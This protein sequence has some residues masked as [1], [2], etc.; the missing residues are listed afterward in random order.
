MFLKLKPSKIFLLALVPTL[1]I[2][3]PSFSQ[4]K[5]IDNEQTKLITEDG[6]KIGFQK[7][8]IASKNSYSIL[9][10]NN[11]LNT[12]VHK[13]KELLKETISIN[14]SQ[15]NSTI[16]IPFNIG[17]D[18]RII[19]EKDENGKAD[20]AAAI[21]NEK[22]DTIG[23]ISTPTIEDENKLEISSVSLKDKN[24]LQLKLE[25][26]DV[27]NT[28]VN[29]LSVALAATYYSTYFSSG[30]WITR[31]GLVSLSL[32]HKPYLFSGT[33]NERSL[34]RSD[35]WNKVKAVH[36]GNSKWKNTSGLYDQYACHLGT[37][38]SRK[39]PYN[40]EPARPDVSYA[41]TIGW[42]CN[43]PIK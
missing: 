15:S 4:A 42:A 40:L 17:D 11:D 38:G 26:K 10:L 9:S 16:N 18:E 21:Y 20:G 27:N 41:E 32:T 33:T 1:F 22:D 39:N 43:P 35:S 8:S 36:S 23:I 31:D 12:D 24:T 34:K 3:Q 29:N 5:Q 14:P 19:L 25:S 37:I 30:K 28:E 2:S 6:N 13:D 7:P